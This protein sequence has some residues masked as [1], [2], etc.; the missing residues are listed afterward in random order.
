MATYAIG[1]LHGCLEPLQRLIEKIRFDQ[2]SDTLWFVGDII[3]RGPQSLETLRFVKSLGDT[4]ITVL[5]NHD[6]HLLAVLHGHRKPSDKDTLKHFMTCYDRD[7]IIDWIRTR[8]LLHVDNERQITMVHAGI[9]PHWDLPQAQ[10]QAHIVEQALQSA[11]Y[12][13]FLSSMYSDKPAN[14]SASHKGQKQLRFAVNVLTRMRYCQ[15]DGSLDFSYNGAP[16]RAPVHL[17]P[18]YAVPRESNLPGTVL[19]GHWSAHPA[20]AP[21]GIVPFD[22]GCVWDGSLVAYDVDAHESHWVTS[23][24]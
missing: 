1:D 6:L 18:W 20:I 9:H 15:A 2:S 24:P 16:H 12:Q 4:A 22:R 8:K 14:W 19:F 3:N 11:D 13:N 5:G 17:L 10:A 7:E 21:P 23:N